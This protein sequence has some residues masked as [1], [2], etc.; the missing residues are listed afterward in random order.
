MPGHAF[1]PA[2]RAGH[3]LDQRRPDRVRIGERRAPHIGDERHAPARWIAHLGEGLRHRVGR[4]LHQRAMEGRGD[5]QQHGAAWRR[6]ALAMRDRPLDRRLVRRRR[7]PGRR[8][9]RWRPRRPRPARRRAAI[10]RGGSKIEAEQRRHGA[11]ARPARP[12]AWR[13]R[14]CAAAARYRAMREAAGGGERRIF[15]ERMAGDEGGVALAGRDPPRASSTRNDGQADRHQRRLGIVGERQL[16]LRTLPHDGR[17]L[18]RRAP[19]STSSKTARAA[20]KASASALPMPTAWLPWP[21]KMN[22]VVMWS[23]IVLPLRYGMA[24]D[25][26]TPPSAAK[27]SAERTVI[28]SPRTPPSRRFG[29][30]RGRRTLYKTALRCCSAGG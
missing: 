17:E 13:R 5:R 6:A 21:G 10:A 27:S 8:H 7:R 26:V 30:C 20:G 28:G 9:C 1:A 23:S 19:S 3:L 12:S 15:A 18:L 11:L 14:G 16:V 29:V 22:A 24:A 25:A 4:R 2:H